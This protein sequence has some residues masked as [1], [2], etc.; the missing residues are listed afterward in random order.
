MNIPTLESDRL[1]L[2]AYAPEDIEAFVTILSNPNAVQYLP[3]SEP[4]PREI[5]E[6]WLLSSRSHWLQEGF[7]WWILEHKDAA[8]A[9]GWCG[10]RRLENTGEVEVLYLLAEEYWGH[11]LATEAARHS[12]EYGFHSVGLDEI[13]GLVLEE[14]IASSRVLEKSG[15]RFWQRATYFGFECLKYR[16]DRSDFA[17]SYAVDQ[18]DTAGFRS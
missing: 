8:R 11:G 13:I 17:R 12:I 16:I 7:G 9:I 6:K 10:L 4:W 5:V 15:L 18:Q 3:M 2:R 1:L 14:N